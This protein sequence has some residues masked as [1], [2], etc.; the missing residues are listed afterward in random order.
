MVLS[1][2]LTML[3]LL[4]LHH[5]LLHWVLH[6]S[7][8]LHH[9]HETTGS[10][11]SSIHSNI[12]PPSSPEPSPFPSNLINLSHNHLDPLPHNL[13]HRPLHNNSTIHYPLYL[14]HHFSPCSLGPVISSSPLLLLSWPYLPP[15]RWPSWRG[16]PHLTTGILCLF[17]HPPS[18]PFFLRVLRDAP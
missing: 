6:R 12:S 3:L 11:I 7:S 16:S 2:R 14:L 1:P 10:I 8:H 15:E 5:R 13:P 17:P 4:Y 9:L 18:L